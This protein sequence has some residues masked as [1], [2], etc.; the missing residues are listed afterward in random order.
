MTPHELVRKITE[1]VRQGVASGMPPGY[2]VIQFHSD[3]RSSIAFD[4]DCRTAAEITMTFRIKFDMPDEP[5]APT[6]VE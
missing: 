2:R 5:D 1:A 6:I 3:G 4:A